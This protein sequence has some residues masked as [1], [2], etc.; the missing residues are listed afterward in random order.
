MLGKLFKSVI[1]TVRPPQVRLEFIQDLRQTSTEPGGDIEAV[2][3]VTPKKDVVH[4]VE[5]S[6][7][8]VLE[9]EIV[10]ITTIM[11]SDGRGSHGTGQVVSVPKTIRDKTVDV[12]RL[13]TVTFLEKVALQPERATFPVRFSVPEELPR[14]PANAVESTAVWKLE[15]VLKLT[16]GSLFRAERRITQG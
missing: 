5:A 10:R 13:D 11:V 15:A 6:A 8:L 3:A 2:V 9:F 14:P 12:H 4:V 16:D 7:S 1:E